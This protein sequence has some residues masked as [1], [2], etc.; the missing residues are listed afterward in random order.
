M[1]QTPKKTN[2]EKEIDRL[3]FEKADL[4]RKLHHEMENVKMLERTVAQYQD[5]LHHMVD[6]ICP[7]VK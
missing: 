5:I 7:K 2:A 3:S 4:L 6:S 1:T